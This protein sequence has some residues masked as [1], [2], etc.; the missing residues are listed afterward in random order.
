M[1]DRSLTNAPRTA[2]AIYRDWAIAKVFGATPE[3]VAVIVNSE[4]GR[5]LE[6]TSPSFWS[7]YSEVHVVRELIATGQDFTEALIEIDLETEIA[8]AA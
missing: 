3:Q 5:S 6:E 2:N 7:Y 8:Q 1:F 4:M